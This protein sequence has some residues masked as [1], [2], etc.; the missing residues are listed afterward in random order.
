MG[1]IQ[2]ITC[3]RF[4]IQLFVS[5]GAFLIGRPR[6]EHFQFRMLI[7]L[8]VYSICTLVYYKLLSGIEIAMPLVHLC[9]YMGLF[10]LSLMG[11]YICFELS[12]MEVLFAGTGGYATEHITFAIVR[13]I[14]YLTGWDEKILG[15]AL[16]YFIFRLFAYVLVAG[17]MYFLVLRK[18]RDKGEFRENDIRIV[19]MSM[20]ILV[21]AIVFSVFYTATPVSGD[22]GVYSYLICPAYSM[23]CCVLVILMEQYL[24]RENRLSREK[25]TMD[26]LL[27]IA[28]AQQKSS[29]EAI[30]IINLKCH[31]LKHQMRH[32]QELQNDKER[33]EYI[34]ELRDA[35]SIYDA[36][37]HTGCETLDYILREKTLIS[38]ER[39]IAF[40]CMVDGTALNF[41]DKTDLYALMGNALDNALEQEAK[42]EPEKRII[43][44]RIQKKGLMAMIHLE[45]TCS[46]EPVFHEGLPLTTK[47]DKNQHGFGVRS[48]VYIVSKYDGNLM[49]HVKDNKFIL[50]IGIPMV[51]AV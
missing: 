2:L 23:M 41:M 4:S 32:L 40:S 39:N 17:I 45:N 1:T 46:I 31:D 48:M 30:D 16:E 47:S 18:N 24:F 28:N 12:W 29:K 7:S 27:Q 15:K 38:D 43:S 3:L 50:D 22:A 26:Q 37:Y 6:K 49:M 51:D 9:F 33:S 19:K 35:I 44:L 34:E 10:A 8:I 13:I 20:L 25:E 21:S 14:Q 36:T 42:E 11:I 5:E